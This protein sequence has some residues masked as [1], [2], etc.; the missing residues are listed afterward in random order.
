MISNLTKS[1]GRLRYVLT[2]HEKYVLQAEK[3]KRISPVFLVTVSVAVAK[4]VFVTVA[5]YGLVLSV[6]VSYDCDCECGYGC[7]NDIMT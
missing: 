6:T 7:Y 3:R 4:I 2:I 1:R 5:I